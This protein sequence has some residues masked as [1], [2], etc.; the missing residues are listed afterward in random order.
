MMTLYQKEDSQE[1]FWSMHM[2]PGWRP[3]P[4]CYADELS[5]PF[6]DEQERAWWRNSSIMHRGRMIGPHI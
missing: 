2:P 1:L 6:K 4:T 3:I 5:R